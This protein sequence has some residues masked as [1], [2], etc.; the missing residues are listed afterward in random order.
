MILFFLVY[1]AVVNLDMS[2]KSGVKQNGL[3]GSHN[4]VHNNG[5]NN[6]GAYNNGG[7]NN[8]GYS[9]GG[10]TTNG[11]ISGVSNGTKQYHGDNLGIC[12]VSC[13]CEGGDVWVLRVHVTLPVATQDRATFR[14][15]PSGNGWGASVSE[16]I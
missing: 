7:N 4:G 13:T 14:P 3:N 10:I 1:S 16:V 15:A 9:N 5:S 8:G 11:G 6:N 2:V 12:Y